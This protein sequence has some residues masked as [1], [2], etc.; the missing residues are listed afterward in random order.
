MFCGVSERQAGGN[1]QMA[2]REGRE[3][4]EAG[5]E[6]GARGECVWGVAR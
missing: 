5:G 2:S 4:D 1:G 3:Q 6:K